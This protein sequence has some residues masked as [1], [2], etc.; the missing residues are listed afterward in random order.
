M[1]SAS[2]TL[3][4]LTYFTVDRPEIG[5]TRLCRLAG[6]DK[7]TTYRHLQ[8]LE[9][10][11]FVEQNP[12]TKNYRLGPRLLQL[13]QIRE[14]TVPRSA[15]VEAPLN[16]LA[17]ATGETSHVSVLS[18]QTLYTLE[19][20]ESPRHSIRVIMDVD[21]FPLHATSSGHCAL[22]FGPPALMDVAAGS[23]TAFTETTVTDPQDL[24]TRVEVTRSSGFARSTGSF[25]D[26]VYSLGVPLFDQT[27]LFAGAVSTASVASRF[28]P[29]LEQIIKS[30]L[31]I[32]ARAITRN[33][34]G[35][36]PASVE[37]AWAATLAQPQ[38]LEP[39]T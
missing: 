17:D 33:W 16:V 14:V 15:G 3:D 36:V 32:A 9:G 2:K 11:G 25:E 12:L 26:D 35:T 30:H 28:T 37:A 7:A 18:G 31:I 4:L 10:A 34:G 39:S 19:A 5:L 23:L 21:T 27:G 29:E 8:S 38:E 1:S 20:V 6:R 13:A 22:A 24:R